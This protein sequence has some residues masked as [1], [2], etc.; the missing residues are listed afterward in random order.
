MNAEIPLKVKEKIA[1][2]VKEHIYD[3]YAIEFGELATSE[4]VELILKETGPFFYQQGIR[5]IKY[6]LH[7]KIIN[8]ESDI[9]SLEEPVKKTLSS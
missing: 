2:K 7:Q 1:F 4:L 5:D 8:L 6:L 3:E 9:K